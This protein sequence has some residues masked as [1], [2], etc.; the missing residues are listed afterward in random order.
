MDAPHLLI[1]K[2]PH[3][4]PNDATSSPP[5]KELHGLAT[6]DDFAVKSPF[7]QNIINCTF[8]QI[9]LNNFAAFKHFDIHAST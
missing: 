3:S 8:F 5:T 6:L 7:D 4:Q 9:H 1:L 2:L